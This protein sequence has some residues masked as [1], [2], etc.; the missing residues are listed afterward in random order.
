VTDQDEAKADA[1]EI[2]ENATD[3]EV[4]EEAGEVAEEIEEDPA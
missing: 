2:A 3:P 4:A 1:E